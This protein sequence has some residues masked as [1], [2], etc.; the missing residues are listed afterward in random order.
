[1]CLVTILGMR[2]WLACAVTPRCP[3]SLSS[4]TFA[5]LSNVSIKVPFR[6]DSG[7]RR[8][9]SIPSTEEIMLGPGSSPDPSSSSSSVK[10]LPLP[11]PLR[12]LLGPAKKADQMPVQQRVGQS[13]TSRTRFINH[14]QVTNARLVQC[15]LRFY[16]PAITAQVISNRVTPFAFIS[17]KPWKLR[18]DHCVYLAKAERFVGGSKN[19]ESGHQGI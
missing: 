5:L 17:S 10:A 7:E 9:G 2:L 3:A 15:T 18:L 6:A 16:K 1:M 13:L 14:P 12:G 4:G 19:S 11:R 8:A